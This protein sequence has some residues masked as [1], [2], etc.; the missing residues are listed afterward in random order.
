MA[1][2]D[3]IVYGGTDCISDVHYILDGGISGA[4]EEY[5]GNEV[6]SRGVREK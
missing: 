2:R 1:D 5:R 4:R 3:R 6:E